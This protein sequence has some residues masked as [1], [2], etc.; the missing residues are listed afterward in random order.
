MSANIESTPINNVATGV[1]PTPVNVPYRVNIYTNTTSEII[2]IISGVVLRKFPQI[3]V[4]GT[5]RDDKIPTAAREDSIAQALHIVVCSEVSPEF[6]VLANILVVKHGI[7]SVLFVAW[8]VPESQRILL[9]ESA[10]WNY[11]SAC[12]HSTSLK[13]LDRSIAN[14]KPPKNES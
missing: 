8:D 1:Q 11:T 6:I 4:V 9:A 12:N 7:G 13:N 3:R 5:Y 10:L 14:M 2:E